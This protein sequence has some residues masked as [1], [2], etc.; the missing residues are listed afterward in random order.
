VFQ[1]GCGHAFHKHCIAQWFGNKKKCPECQRLFAKVIG[2]G[3]REGTMSWF[4]EDW[5]LHGHPDSLQ[6]LVVHFEFPSAQDESG[7]KY[8]GRKPKCYLPA[9][10]Q[11]V[12]LLELFKVALRRRV[13]FGLGDSATTNVYRPT[14]NVHIKTSSRGGQVHHGYPDDSYFQ[15]ALGEL[16][17]NGVI[18]SDL[19]A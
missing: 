11:G 18:L 13:M 17:D 8:S 12:V 7:R 4:L 19:P 5:A 15:R 10:L 1:L 9:N 6:T 2:A 3:P 16:R 14:F